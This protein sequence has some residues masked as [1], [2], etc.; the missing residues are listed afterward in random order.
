MEDHQQIS[1]A[2]YQAFDHM[3][4]LKNDF[5]VFHGFSLTEARLLYIIAIRAQT[6]SHT[7]LSTLAEM[8]S[9]TRSAVSQSVYKLEQAGLIVKR[10][11]AEDKRSV[12]LDLTQ[13]AEYLCNQHIDELQNIITELLNHMGKGRILLL[14]ELI[15]E[16]TD[17][18][19]T[20]FERGETC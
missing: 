10:R 4:I 2:L 16:F 9:L 18:I 3:R 20:Y 15:T 14:T 1:T 11:R 5:V 12:T 7:N 17:I 6:G 13:K 19:Q 8:L